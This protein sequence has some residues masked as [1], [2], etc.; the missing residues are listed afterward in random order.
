MAATTVSINWHS[1]T[2][3]CVDGSMCGSSMQMWVGV[4]CGLPE[5]HNVCVCFCLCGYLKSTM[6]V[7]VLVSCALPDVHDA[8]VCVGVCVVT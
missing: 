1:H 2:S 5:V 7:C 4:M 8:R 3:V 6:R